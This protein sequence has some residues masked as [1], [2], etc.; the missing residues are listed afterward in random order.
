MEVAAAVVAQ[1]NR[2]KPGQK[3][4]IRSNGDVEWTVLAGV[5]L[6]DDDENHVECVS[7][8]TGVK[9]VPERARAYSHGTIVMDNHA[10]ILALR[11][12]NWW[13]L[14]KVDDDTYFEDNNS[15]NANP[16]EKKRRRLKSKYAVKLYISE[17]PCGDALMSYIAQDQ[18]AWKR[19]KT[20]DDNGTA[21][22]RGRAHFDDLGIVRTK[23][24]RGDSEVLLSKLCSDKLAAK[25][26]TGVLNAMASAVV[27]PIY[28][29][30]VVVPES[31]YSEVDFNRCFGRIH[32]LGNNDDSD[33]F[34]VHHDM[35]ITTTPTEFDYGKH[36]D[37][38]AAAVSVIAVV[39]G[40]VDTLV[41]GVKLGSYQKHRAPK[42]R[43]QSA[44][45]NRQLWQRWRH[46]W[47]S[48]DDAD[49]DDD[50]TTYVGFKRSQR[51]RQQLKAH[52]R[53][54]LGQWVATGSDDFPLTCTTKPPTMK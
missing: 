43:G 29:A 18:P 2:L 46:R 25:Q 26:V 1:F 30:E 31:K 4:Q 53:A 40:P 41:H 52:V 28:L 54:R 35:A 8:A 17:P 15:E 21:V 39:G 11:A 47:V 44:F 48:D 51:R 36:P 38:V 12:F 33:D 37:K 27:E 32:N 50:I 10:E 19:R 6:V 7:F 49:N 45:C 14:S 24:G 9:V 34:S 42:D 3:P 5:C 23:P 16:E 22:V 13:V 20:S